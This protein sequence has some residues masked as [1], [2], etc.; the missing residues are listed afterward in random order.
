VVVWSLPLQAG[1]GGPSP[2][3]DK[4]PLTSHAETKR[5]QHTASTQFHS[6]DQLI[7]ARLAHPQAS[8]F[9]PPRLSPTPLRILDASM[10][11]QRL[12]VRKFSDG[13]SRYFYGPIVF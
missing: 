10:C 9:W 2:I 8:P 12:F 13:F 1:S 4:A 7:P 5:S 6:P 11:R 3:S